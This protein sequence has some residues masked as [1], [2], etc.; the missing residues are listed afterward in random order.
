MIRLAFYYLLHLVT[1]RPVVITLDFDGAERIRMVRYRLTDGAP[2]VHAIWGS[3]CC[4]LLRLD[5]TATG[6][7]YVDEWRPL[8]G[9]VFR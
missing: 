8:Y 5:G 7:N 9:E 6:V 4:A 3:G 2:Y 1:R